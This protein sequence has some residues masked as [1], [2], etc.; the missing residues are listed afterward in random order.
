[1][2]SFRTPLD[3][4]FDLKPRYL[5]IYFFFKVKIFSVASKLAAL[6]GTTLHLPQLFSRT[7]Q[8]CFAANIKRTVKL[9]LTFHRH[10]GE[11]IMTESSHRVELFL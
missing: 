6:V 5:H 1:M 3:P 11:E 4:K 8:L 10:E 7:L 2:S 9:P